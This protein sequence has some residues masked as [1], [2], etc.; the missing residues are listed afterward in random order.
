MDFT[1]YK[2]SSLSLNNANVKMNF[3]MTV[4]IN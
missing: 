4:A 1:S 3:G 2:I